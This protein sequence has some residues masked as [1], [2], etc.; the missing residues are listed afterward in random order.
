MKVL[1]WLVSFCIKL[2][3]VGGLINPEMLIFLKVYE[4]KAK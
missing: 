2:L 1:P 4:I 3:Q